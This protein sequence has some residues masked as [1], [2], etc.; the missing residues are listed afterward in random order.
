VNMPTEELSNHLVI[1]GGGRVGQHI[2]NIFTQMKVNFI[3]IE[4]NY[5]RF[6]QCK[7]AGFPAIYGDASQ[8]VILEGANIHQAGLLLH[9]IPNEAVSLALI[10]GV[11]KINKDLTIVTRAAEAEEMKHLYDSGVYMVVLPELEAG[12]EMARQ[13]LIQLHVP[14]ITIQECLDKVRMQ[15]YEPELTEQVDYSTIA[16]LKNAKDLL[17]I[18]WMNLFSDSGLIGHTIKELGIR[19]RTGGIANLSTSYS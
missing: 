12:L 13:A 17:E 3:I 18:K 11:K 8:E 10:R 16:H 9:T 14:V 6:Q 19:S 15:H 5:Q 4:L 2:A 1:S 7:Q